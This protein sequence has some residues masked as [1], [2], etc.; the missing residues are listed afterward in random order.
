MMNL[1]IPFI[2]FDKKPIGVREVSGLLDGEIQR[3]I[4]IMPWPAFSYKP[5]A[6]FAIA[7]N[8]QHI[9]LKYYVEEHAI[10]ALHRNTNGPVYRDSC[11][12]F[13]ISFNDE[14]SYY[15]LEFNCAGSCR[16]GYGLNRTERT[17]VSKGLVE[18]INYQ[19]VFKTA[20]ST[21]PHTIKWELTLV[22][23]II[24]FSQH[25]IESLESKSCRVNFYKCGDDLPEPH[26]LSWTEMTSAAPNFHQ[27]A[28]FGTAYFAGV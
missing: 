8:G 24:V 20:P 5:L 21:I 14:R 6:S 27:P 18:K 22:I 10:M 9:F 23:P 26:Y 11:V 4:N 3:P 2:P 1:E 16:M 19:V 28:D 7:H 13:F 25:Q 17:A 12:E 15:N